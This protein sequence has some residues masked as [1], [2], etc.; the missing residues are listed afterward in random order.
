MHGSS[1]AVPPSFR[2]Q[3]VSPPSWW[4]GPGSTPA[5]SQPSRGP[6]T[7]A[8]L[9]NPGHGV[10]VTAGGLRSA[11]GQHRLQVSGLRP[12]GRAGRLHD[13]RL[14][15]AQ[16]SPPRYSDSGASRLFFILG[17]R[18]PVS[19][20]ADALPQGVQG[21]Q[22]PPGSSHCLVCLPPSLAAVSAPGAHQQLGILH[23]TSGSSA[24]PEGPPRG[25]HDLT[26]PRDLLNYQCSDLNLR[27]PSAILA[28]GGYSQLSCLRFGGAAGGSITELSAVSGSLGSGM[29][30]YPP[31]RHTLCEVDE[32]T[33]CVKK[34]QEELK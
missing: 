8:P 13:C 11:P 10:R 24:V 16:P 15:R 3:R 31:N 33:G 21:P 2:I 6:S 32:E 18:R 1:P 5:S 4:G 9:H 28:P 19:H 23:L 12:P 26:A 27:P 29:T 34:Y 22:P 20:S 17:G 25:I 7:A 30:E 14:S